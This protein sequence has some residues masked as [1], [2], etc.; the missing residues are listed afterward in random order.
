MSHREFIRIHRKNNAEKGADA[1]NVVKRQ[2]V[3]A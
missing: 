3:L 2:T 1:P